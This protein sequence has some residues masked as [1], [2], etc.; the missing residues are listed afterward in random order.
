M[1]TARPK[2][3]SNV[4]YL[5]HISI[6]VTSDSL[7]L[8]VIKGNGRKKAIDDQLSIS[9]LTNDEAYIC[10]LTICNSTILNIS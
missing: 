3:L 4:M 10:R 6:D 2:I 5:T 9:N 8:A 7:M 1:S